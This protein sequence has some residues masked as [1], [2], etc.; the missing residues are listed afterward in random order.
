MGHEQQLGTQQADAFRAATARIGVAGRA[1]GEVRGRNYSQGDDVD[2]FIYAPPADSPA[3][4]VVEP[5]L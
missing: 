4:A 3:P 5:P 1:V 2:L